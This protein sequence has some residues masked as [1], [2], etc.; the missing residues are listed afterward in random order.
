M[1][2]RELLEFAAKAANIEIMFWSGRDVGAESP[3]VKPHGIDWNPLTDDGDAFRLAVKLNL[4]NTRPK[5]YEWPDA[6][7][8]A[9]HQDDPYA[10]T[11]RAVVRAAAEIGKKMK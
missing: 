1:N 10:A 6:E 8:F 3:V 11:R 4:F 7:L 2:D 9:R 5:G